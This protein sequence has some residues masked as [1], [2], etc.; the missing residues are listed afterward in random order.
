MTD[1]ADKAI[2]RK[3]LP[4]TA[5]LPP[6]IATANG[7]LSNADIAVNLL[8][9]IDPLTANGYRLYLFYP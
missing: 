9:D 4:P 3:V 1:I 5:Y 2:L 6:N 7:M 8:I